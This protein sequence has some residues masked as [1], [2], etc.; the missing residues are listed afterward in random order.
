MHNPLI[1]FLRNEL[2]GIAA[3]S[4][5]CVCLI[6]LMLWLSSPTR[7]KKPDDILILDVVCFNEDGEI[8]F[9]EWVDSVMRLND[10]TIIYAGQGGSEYPYN[11]ITGYISPSTEKC[12]VRAKKG[13]SVYISGPERKSK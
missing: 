7:P 12:K 9:N 4:L 5:L 6:H 13:I 1:R 8:V 2:F 10:G 11:R 3:L